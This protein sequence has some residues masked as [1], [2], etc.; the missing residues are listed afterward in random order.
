[1]KNIRIA[2]LIIYV[3]ILAIFSSSC[4][5]SITAPAEL[6]KRPGLS[7]D[8]RVAYEVIHDNLPNMAELVRP[9]R[10]GNLTAVGYFNWNDDGEEEVYAFYKNEQASLAGVVL[11]KLE[12]GVW[13]L[14][15]KIEVPGTDVAYAKFIDLN[16]DGISDLLIGTEGREGVY[17][18]ID[19]Y[20]WDEGEYNE[21]WHDVF[22]ELLATD[23]DMD[24]SVELVNVKLDR[25]NY[26]TVSVFRYVEDKFELLDEINLDMYI[27]GYYNVVP[28]QIKDGVNSVVMDFSLGSRT[29]TNVIV[30]ADGKLSTIIDPFQAS[31]NYDETSK[32]STVKSRDI[33][34]DGIIEIAKSFQLKYYEDRNIDRRDVYAW[35]NFVGNVGTNEDSELPE[36]RFEISALSYVD[37]MNY[38]EFIF[39]DKW[40]RAALNGDLI[41]VKSSENQSRNFVS[42]FCLAKDDNPVP[43]ITLEVF[44]LES[45]DEWM[46]NGINKSYKVVELAGGVDFRI[47]AYYVDEGK[48]V[49]DMDIQ[50]YRSMMIDDDDIRVGFS[51]IR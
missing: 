4:S 2:I 12:D 6:I 10:P 40:T 9:L 30:F 21:V 16:S 38:F 18:V 34:G 29:A 17:H 50:K 27:S 45:Y 33:D 20:V 11:L 23:L 3:L 5:F 32:L 8:D 49:R 24:G 14:I 25:A 36:H 13:K 44:D 48:H 22:T 26:S 39:P 46:E 15:S 43:L 42:F 41:L 28:Y 1:M 51:L 47:I 37:P 7:I 31:Q 19:A 35:Q